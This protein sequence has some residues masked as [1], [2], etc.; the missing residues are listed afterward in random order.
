[1]HSYDNRRVMLDSGL[2]ALALRGLRSRDGHYV[3]I[4]RH[5]RWRRV[6]VSWRAV[7]QRVAASFPT[8]GSLFR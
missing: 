5:T 3:F 6:G 1:M 2:T 4:E 7:R 8:L